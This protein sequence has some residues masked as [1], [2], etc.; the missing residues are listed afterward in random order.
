MCARFKKYLMLAFVRLPSPSASV[1]LHLAIDVLSSGPRVLQVL[2]RVWSVRVLGALVKV[3]VG[4]L[5]A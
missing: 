3:L 4:V 2:V 5:K 1:Y